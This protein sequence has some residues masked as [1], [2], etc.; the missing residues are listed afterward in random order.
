MWAVEE[1][2]RHLV[3]KSGEA[4]RLEEDAT[5]LRDQMRTEARAAEGEIRQLRETLRHERDLLE[6]RMA[7]HAVALEDG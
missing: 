7:E 1:V 3:A 4:R 2:E 5:V 6:R